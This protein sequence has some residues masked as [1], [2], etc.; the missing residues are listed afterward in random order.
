VRPALDAAPRLELPAEATK[1]AQARR[2][3]VW[4]RLELVLEQMA[5]RW[6]PS[7]QRRVGPA[8]SPAS[9][10]VLRER[11]ES[12]PRPEPAQDAVAEPAL[13]RLAEAV[14]PAMVHAPAWPELAQL[15]QA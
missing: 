15:V 13:T 9:A 8:A 3:P 5:V 6:A 12:L 10:A 1:L 14:R 7:T 4:R 2:E 11:Q